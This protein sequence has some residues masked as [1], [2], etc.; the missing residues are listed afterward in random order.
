MYLDTRD[1]VTDLDG[2]AIK[3][4][5]KPV[6]FGMACK[7]AAEATD[8]TL[9]DQDAGPKRW[10][11]W[12]LAKRIRVC[13]R[14]DKGDGVFKLDNDEATML[15]ELGARPYAMMR[16]LYGDFHAVLM[17]KRTQVRAAEKATADAKS[18]AVPAT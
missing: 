1:A 4:N 5:G 14:D 18:E 13:E 11:A 12:D 17:G 9:K 16:A 2:E 15:C 7:I 10:E 8:P 6:T 3:Q